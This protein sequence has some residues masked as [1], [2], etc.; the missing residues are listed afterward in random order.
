MTSN[1]PLT[2]TAA[3]GSLVLVIAVVF[4]LWPSDPTDYTLTSGRDQAD[5]ETVGWVSK[6]EANTIHV[7]SGPFGGGVVPLVV[8]RA[9][10]ITVGS[11]EGWFED[12]R[13]G[14]Q[15]KVTYE[16]NHGKRLARSVELLVEEGGLRRPV[17]AE[18]RVKS[19][20]DAA[21]ESVPAKASA[22][23]PPTEGRPA[24]AAKPAGAP[25]PIASGV[26]QPAPRPLEPAALPEARPVAKPERAR[27]QPADTAASRPPPPPARTGAPA[28]SAARAQDAARPSTTPA[29]ARPTEP[30][31]AP[32]SG[33]TTDG[34]DAVDWL[35]KS[36]R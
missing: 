28:D 6:V 25:Q 21:A 22:F 9:T 17:R 15:V 32:D 1:R 26:K 8:T 31:Q 23:T 19:T 30:G 33:G 24:P 4:M 12:I 35:L 11:K 3:V 36:R 5:G 18:P 29:P 10:R 16:V 20:T 34:S 14:G 2:F 13:P 27:P 7:N